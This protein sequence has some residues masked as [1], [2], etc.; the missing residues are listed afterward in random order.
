MTVIELGLVTDGGE[1][2]PAGPS[3]RGL[4]RNELRRVLVAVVA[5]VCVLTVTGS[6]RPDP[7]GPQRLWSTP[8]Q[9]G[10]DSFMVSGDAA[11]VLAQAGTTRVT[12]YDLRTGAVRWSNSNIGSPNWLGQI[13]AGVLL[14]PGDYA[15]ARFTDLDGTEISREFTRDT[16][17]VDTATGRRLWHRPGEMSVAT[18]DRVL[19]TE[20]N[21][22]G[23]RVTTLRVVRISD[24]VDIWSRPAGHLA[25]WVTDTLERSEP[26]RLVTATAKGEVEVLDLADGS[27][28]A[29]ATLPWG[30][31]SAPDNQDTALTMQGH[32]L[33]VQRAEQE[34]TSITAYDTETLRRMWHIESDTLGGAY[35]CGPVLCMRGPDGASG[36]DSDTGELRWRLPGS[37]DA[38]PLGGGKLLVDDDESGVRH[39]L[40]DVATG[41]RLADL[42]TGSPVWNYTTAASPY[43][44]ANTRE[45][46]GLVSISQYD[47]RS[48]ELL[49]RG[50]MPPVI[51]YGCQ[52]AGSLLACVTQDG[53]LAVTDVG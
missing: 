12:A 46:A 32:R 34:R 15:T 8:F 19:L 26:G 35:D 25:V 51:E 41:R 13:Q 42:G 2:P 49:L 24:G 11:Y 30:R 52:S 3:R 1:Q 5:I 27:V 17:A 36:Y 16:V 37:P 18:D 53:L 44:L 38:F 14:L 22:D 10:A 50:T 39:H 20:W 28:V 48:G 33:Y 6:A 23:S 29:A 21:D 43:L 31:R 45:P 40:V 4:R 7:H 47:E 9:Q